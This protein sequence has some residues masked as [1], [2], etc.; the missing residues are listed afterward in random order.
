MSEQRYR[1]DTSEIGHIYINNP[2]GEHMSW[3]D[4]ETTL[5]GQ[6]TIIHNQEKQ[7]QRLYNYFMDYLED[8]MS[9]DSFSEMWDGVK[10]DEKWD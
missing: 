3:I 10:E 4:V 1:I 8:E 6:Q 2:E 5:N 9:A 7:M